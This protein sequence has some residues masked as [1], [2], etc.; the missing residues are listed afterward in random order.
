MFLQHGM[1]TEK[2]GGKVYHQINGIILKVSEQNI[3][4]S[5]HQ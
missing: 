1:K 5:Y 2:L 4:T 3:F